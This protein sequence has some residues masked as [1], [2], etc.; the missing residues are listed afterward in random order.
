MTRQG[1]TPKPH[2]SLQV[3][4]ATLRSNTKASQF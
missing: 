2:Q 1:K 3:T 4:T